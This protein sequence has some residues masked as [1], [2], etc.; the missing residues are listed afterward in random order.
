M[1]KSKKVEYEADGDNEKLVRNIAKMINGSS[2]DGTNFAF[3]LGDEAEDDPSK[4]IDWV[5]S[6]N[7]EL[8]L[9]MANRPNGGY[10]VGR[11]TEITG[12]E[13]S[14]KT[15][16]AMHALAE[17]QK[18]GG[19]AVF[20]DTESSLDLNFVRAIGVKAEQLCYISCDHVEE[21]FDHLEKI[22]GK[23]RQD[24]KDKLVTIVVDSVSAASCLTEMES[25]HGK[26]GYATAK[27]IIISK[28]MRKITQMIAR[29]RVCLIFTNQVRQNLGVTFG[30]KWTTSGGKGIAF[31]SSI[32]IRMSKIKQIK[33]T[34]GLVMGFSSKAKVFKN[35]L[36]P[37]MRE[38]EFDLFF[39]RGM[40]NYGSWFNTVENEKIASKAKTQEQKKKMLEKD[41]NALVNYVEAGGTGKKLQFE[42]SDG[43]IYEFTKSS[44]TEF[45]ENNLTIKEEIYK[46]I[47]DAKIMVYKDQSTCADEDLIYEEEE[48]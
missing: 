19:V 2:S 18:K 6:G 21:I 4:I 27:A 8:D 23:V 35:R 30:D 16:L 37:P 32:R 31:H 22:I 11:I 5:P 28:A 45:L 33:H 14:G 20:I 26:D 7:D 39:D 38:A 12:L 17:T 9:A 41:E 1:A 44:F 40:D 10:P 29:Q 34:N 36:G 3:I 13:G 48:S 46:K 24:T 47:C 43:K 25:D 42:S 15:L